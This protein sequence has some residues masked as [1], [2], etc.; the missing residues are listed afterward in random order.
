MN[1]FV[2][3]AFLDFLRVKL[4]DFLIGKFLESRLLLLKPN[5]EFRGCRLSIELRLIV[6]DESLPF[7]E[8]LSQVFIVVKLKLALRVQ[9]RRLCDL[10]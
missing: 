10:F 3:S 7:L 4:F 6:R 8:P 5:L 2:D 1:Y 9:R